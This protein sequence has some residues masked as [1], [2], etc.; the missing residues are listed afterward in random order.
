MVGLFDDCEIQITCSKCGHKTNKK[1]R[2]LKRNSKYHCVCGNIV[3]IDTKQF[4]I[5]IAE[6]DK[7]YCDLQ[8]TV[9]ILHE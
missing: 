6:V 3:S 9:K 7:A 4:K 8:K 1:I 2:W 5:T